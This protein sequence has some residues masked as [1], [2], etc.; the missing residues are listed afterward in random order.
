MA[1]FLVTSALVVTGALLLLELQVAP[2]CTS[3]YSYGRNPAIHGHRHGIG[4]ALLRHRINYVAAEQPATRLLRA[5][6]TQL[7]QGFF[8]RHGFLSSVRHV[9]LTQ[10]A[11]KSRSMSTNFLAGFV[12]YLLGLDG[13][14]RKVLTVASNPDRSA[15][16]FVP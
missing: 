4:S 1:L 3:N 5:N 2:A 15:M 13:D 16:T 6:T 12:T 8:E 10:S 7:A 11:A 9:S 14:K